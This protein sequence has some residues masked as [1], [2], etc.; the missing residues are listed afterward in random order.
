MILIAVN[1]RG[2]GAPGA[3]GAGLFNAYSRG[4]LKLASTDASID[5][6]AHETGN[7]DTQANC[8]TIAMNAGEF[9]RAKQ[10]DHH[11]L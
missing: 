5:P 4:N 3:I 10:P 2:I 6:I 9:G 1:H 7:R 11:V 8:P